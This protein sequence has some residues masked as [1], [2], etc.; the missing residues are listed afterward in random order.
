MVSSSAA[1][2]GHCSAAAIRRKSLFTVCIPGRSA[3]PARRGTYRTWPV[4]G[5]M[6]W[7]ET[8]VA[9]AFPSDDSGLKT[10]TLRH[11]MG[12]QNLE[13]PLRGQWRIRT[14][15]PYTR[16]GTSSIAVRRT[17]RSPFRYPLLDDFSSGCRMQCLQVRCRWRPTRPGWHRRLRSP[18]GHARRRVL[19]SLLR[20]SQHRRRLPPG[21]RRLLASPGCRAAIPRQGVGCATRPHSQGR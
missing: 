16:F 8:P 2:A 12:W 1:C 17:P 14:G 7:C 15:F 5:L 18:V 19:R 9:V 21:T 4:S 20:P 11:P 3:H 10:A 13:L 6:R